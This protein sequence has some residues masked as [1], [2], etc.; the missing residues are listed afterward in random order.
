VQPRGR[1]RRAGTLEADKIETVVR[2]QASDREQ[3]DI[4]SDK[5]A[6]L[7]MYGREIAAFDTP[8]FSNNLGRIIAR[9]T[10]SIARRAG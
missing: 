6:L 10:S 1:P 5:A 9:A 3:P 8:T 7:W 2:E 4:N